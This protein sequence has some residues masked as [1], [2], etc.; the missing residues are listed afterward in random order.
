MSAFW[1][2]V[3]IEKTQIDLNV[4]FLRRG[5]FFKEELI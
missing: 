3:A 1:K 5:E 4:F 2:E